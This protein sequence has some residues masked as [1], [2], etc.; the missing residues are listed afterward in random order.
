MSTSKP[1]RV[2]LV[3]V[4]ACTVVFALSGPTP[5]LPSYTGYMI[6][7]WALILTI[8]EDMD[9]EDLCQ[10]IEE[11]TTVE[12]FIVTTSDLEGY[13]I[14]RYSYL[15]FNDWGIGKADV[16]NGLLL[17]LYYEDLNSTHFAYEFRI[18]VGRGLE[19]AITDA[20]AGRIARDN[21]TAWIDWGYIYEGLYEGILALYYEFMDDPSVV[22][23]Q[24]DPIGLAALQAWAYA[25][26][27]IAGAVIGV[28]LSF[29]FSWANYTVVRGGNC[30]IPLVM[31]GTLTLF[32]WWLDNSLATLFY[33]IVIAFGGTVVISGAGRVRSGG[34]KTSGGGYTSYG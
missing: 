31:I 5:A 14:N 2:L 32:A 23:G 8:E 29:V 19:G 6:N 20:E 22:S 9:L 12:I 33:A 30:I 11:E 25:N 28:F 18:E 17:T 7:D 3:L 27:L 13:D 15:L 21:V 26:P 1:A 10:A 4:L 34:G 16:N 24:G